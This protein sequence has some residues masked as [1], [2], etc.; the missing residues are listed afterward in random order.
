[1]AFLDRL[2]KGVSKAAEQAKFEAD[3]L[4]RVNKLN[5]EIGKL[6]REIEQTT[7]NIGK[8]VIELQ[9]SGVIQIPDL[10]ELIGQVKALET[11]LEA[12][13]VELE[14]VKAAKFEEGIPAEEAASVSRPCPA[15]GATVEAG[16]RFCPACGQK[17]E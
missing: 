7:A 1:M 9:A 5:A 16:A 12:K 8:K 15:C 4:V 14:T 2:T 3:K 11:Q 17:L 6:T 10:D 13:Q